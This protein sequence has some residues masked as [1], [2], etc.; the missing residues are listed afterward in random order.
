MRKLT[1]AYRDDDRTPV[2]FTIREIARRHYGIE[3]DVVKIMG[4]KDYEAALFDGAC[5][6]IV[7]HLEYLYDKAAE[8]EKITMFFAPST[9]GGL[10]LVVPQTVRGA[11]D[12]RGKAMAVRSSGQPHAVALWLRM[13][14]LEKDVKTRIV[15]DAEVGRWAQWKLVASGECI[16]A[17]ISPLYL[18]D[19]LEAGLR[20]LPSPEIPIIGH[21]AQACL[22][23]FAAGNPELLKDYVR[24][25]IHAVCLML[26]NREAALEI[27]AGEPMKRMGIEDE[28]ELERQF[29][30]IVGSLKPKP[31][32]LPQAIANTH[33]IAT[34]DFPA[35]GGLN[36]LSLWNLRWVKELDDEGFIDGLIN[37]LSRQQQTV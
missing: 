4:T 2:I 15:K 29:D 26:F 18:P 3:V 31:Y 28:T 37:A 25:A 19:A 23:R 20:V 22:S 21:F 30:C 35:A 17:F 36:P 33:E 12:F 16:A 13:M 34:K 14:G 1:L 10:K 7:E 24:A 32:P 9:G 27:C 6:V 8:G 5:D 11:D